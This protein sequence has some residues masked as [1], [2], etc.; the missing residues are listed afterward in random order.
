MNEQELK[1]LMGLIGVHVLSKIQPPTPL[2]ADLEA[3]ASDQSAPPIEAGALV[4]EA[5]A[6]SDST[7]PRS[8]LLAPWQYFRLSQTVRRFIQSF[9]GH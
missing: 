8:T 6:A 3:H 2:D 1:A 7:A 4:E 9:W 5:Q